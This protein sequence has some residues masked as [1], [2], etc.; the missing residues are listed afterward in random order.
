VE[1]ASEGFRQQGS[2]LCFITCQ[3]AFLVG[4]AFDG[5]KLVSRAYERLQRM[6]FWPGSMSIKTL[7][8]TIIISVS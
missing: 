7:E 3:A 1:T 4:K 2:I 5:L 8:E 6:L